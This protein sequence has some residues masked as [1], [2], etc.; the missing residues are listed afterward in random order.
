MVHFLHPNRGVMDTCEGV[1]PG[2]TSP[3]E[4]TLFT[5][6]GFTPEDSVTTGH[7]YEQALAAGRGTEVRF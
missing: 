4:I 7:S 6:M 3:R 1:G 5:S 2:R